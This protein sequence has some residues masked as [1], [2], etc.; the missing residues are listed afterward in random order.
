M[1]KNLLI[2]ILV[3]VVVLES[4]YLLYRHFAKSPI[5]MVNQGRPNADASGV[6]KDGPQGARPAMLR[7]G[8]S[9]SASPIKQFAYQIAP[10]TISDAAK[11]KLTGFA[12]TSITNPDGSIS[13]SLTPK[14]SEDQHQQYTVKTGQVLYFIEQTPMD[15]KADSDRDLN[16][17]DDYGIIT[18]ANGIV[19]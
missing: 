16:Y 3:S 7:K 15:D 6:R 5:A 10:G 4:G 11:Q 8:D 1:N 12:I 9:L 19:Q 14:D 18:D 2:G 13:V 17:R